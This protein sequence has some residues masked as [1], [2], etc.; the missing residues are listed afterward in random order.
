MNGEKAFFRKKVFG[1][2]NRDDVVK[3]IAK[4]AEE[5]N[6]ALAAKEKIKKEMQA[7]E[8][9][10]KSLNDQIKSLKEQKPKPVNECEENAEE[11]AEEIAEP[12]STEEPEKTIKRIKIKR[13]K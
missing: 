12:E 11:I 10:I 8:D 4:I 5:R 7:L 2:F 6:E 3:Y 13:R 1:G 9:E